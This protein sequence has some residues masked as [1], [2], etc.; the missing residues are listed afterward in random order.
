[1]SELKERTEKILQAII[2]SYIDLNVPIGSSMVTRRFSFGLSPATIRNIMAALEDLG[3]LKQ[4]YTSAGRVPTERGYKYYVDTL[5]KEYTFSMNKAIVQELFNRL[6]GIEKD[7]QQLINETSKTLSFFSS[8]LGIVTPPRAEDR[9][10]K[11][12][13]VIKYESN[14]ALS[15][16]I[17]GDGTLK[18]RIIDLER[19]YTQRELDKITNYLN[20]SF[21]G[22]SL[23]E[24]KNRVAYQLSRESII[25]DKLIAKSLMVCKEL[26]SVENEDMLMDGLTGASNLPDFT[27]INEI[28]D[29]LKAIE[30]K[31][32]M[33]KLLAQV[34]SSEGVQVFV[35]LENIIPS[36][37]KLSMVVSTYTDSVDARGTIGII[38]PIRMNYRELIPIVDRTAKTLTKVLSES[39]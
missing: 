2:Q 33:L 27:D 10:L 34:D 28:K 8:Y 5:L 23:S 4:P 32:L 26:I 13:R 7:L 39:Q 24:V 21:G 20:I 3:Y 25:C 38:G 12:I 11:H 22:I 16:L 14:K 36:M 15:V 37:K 19:T 17:F 31:H 6:R 1:M 29:I 30:D 9:T 18:N 35:G